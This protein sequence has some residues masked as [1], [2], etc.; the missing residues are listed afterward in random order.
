MNPNLKFIKK[1]NLPTLTLKVTE[2]DKKLLAVFGVFALIVSSYYFLYQPMSAKIETLQSEKA[3]VDVQVVAA[4]TDLKNE[5]QLLLAY[6][7]ILD[8]VNINTGP[9][10]PKV[11]P[12]MDRYILL[13]ENAVK[14]SGATAN[15]ISFSDPVVG[16]VPQPIQDKP[17]ELPSY[18]LQDLAKKINSANPNAIPE[19]AKPATTPKASNTADKAVP[20]DALLR[21]PA[22]LEVN[23]SYEQIR[24][25]IS[26]LENLKRAIAIESIDLGTSENGEV[27]ANFT[28]SFYALEKVDNGADS[29]NLW[30]MQGSY[31]KPDLFN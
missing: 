14:E 5:A 25:V 24:A 18:P 10:F 4:T 13:L 15:K 19:R 20:A 16:A 21:L 31:G 23:G 8:K 2:R 7:T 26:N 28:L 30:T 27:T 1:M 22:T 12:Y 29:F 6:T 9:F 17:F 11:Y 3:N